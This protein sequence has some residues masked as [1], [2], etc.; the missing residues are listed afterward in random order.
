MILYVLSRDRRLPVS[1]SHLIVNKWK[2]SRKLTNDL[3]TPHGTAPIP[4]S[5]KPSWK[6]A[7]LTDWLTDTSVQKTP[8]SHCTSTS[9]IEKRVEKLSLALTRRSSGAFSIEE[10]IKFCAAALSTEKCRARA[11]EKN[12]AGREDIGVVSVTACCPILVWTQRNLASP[13]CFSVRSIVSPSR[14]ASRIVRGDTRIVQT[15]SAQ[16]VIACAPVLD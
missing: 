10:T 11:E 16:E 5:G 1:H 2:E 7:L 13:V 12:G 4:S 3:R 9:I 15:L 6:Q 14:P 8:K